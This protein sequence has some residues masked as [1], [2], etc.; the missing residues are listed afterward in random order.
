MFPNVITTN[1]QLEEDVAVD[2]DSSSDWEN[3]LASSDLNYSG[4]ESESDDED[5]LMEIPKLSKFL[6]TF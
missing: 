1:K 2:S 4:T 5:I 3:S 6:V